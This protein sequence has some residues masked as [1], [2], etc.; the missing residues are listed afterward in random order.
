MQESQ[1]NVLLLPDTAQGYVTLSFAE[2]PPRAMLYETR[3]PPTSLEFARL[4]KL[5][6][7][8]RKFMRFRRFNVK[9]TESSTIMMRNLPDQ[10]YTAL[11][12]SAYRQTIIYAF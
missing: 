5:Y 7:N 9:C 6:V 2:M 1:G 11:P 8:V 4:D 12:V 10:V 3:N